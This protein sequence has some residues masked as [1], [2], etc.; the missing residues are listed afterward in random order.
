MINKLYG[1]WVDYINIKYLNILPTFVGDL[2]NESSLSSIVH[3]VR[4]DLNRVHAL[5]FCSEGAD[6]RPE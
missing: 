1:K 2:A 4:V 6:A 5:M 3:H